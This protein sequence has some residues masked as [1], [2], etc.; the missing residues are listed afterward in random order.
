MKAA[1]AEEMTFWD[2][3]DDLRKRII[4]SLIFV[5][6]ASIILFIYMP[7]L[8]DRVILAPCH[9][10]FIF[11]RWLANLSH[12]VPI[13]PGFFLS[14][15]D[16]NLI[17]VNLATQF[18]TH[19]SLSFW[20][21]VVLSF[22]LIIYQI[23][24]FVRPGLYDHE[25]KNVGW[26]FLFGNFMFF[27]GVVVS[28][29]LVFPLTLRFLATYELSRE[30]KN[31]ISLDSYIDNFTMMCFVMG[32]VFELPLLAMLLSKLGIL[33]RTF[34]HKFRKHALVVIMIL[35]A[36]ITP[37]GD[38][39]TLMVVFLPIYLLWELSALLVKPAPKDLS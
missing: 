17:N 38:P 20:L 5:G 3:L 19:M 9:S 26:V 15:F 16:I 33:R 32:I 25:R 14:R 6:L 23:W 21:A 13:M 11:Y 27:L 4:Y 30:V 36:V 34:F 2:H 37:T 31:F 24:L 35:A 10:D 22:P 29:F 12:V 8:F 1:S 39:F 7:D 28:Y 18:M